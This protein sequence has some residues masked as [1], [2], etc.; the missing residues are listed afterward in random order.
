MEPMSA[1]A[2][3]LQHEI[4][5]YTAL[6][7]Y[8]VHQTDTT[9]QLRKPKQFN[10]LVFIVL[11]VLLFIVGAVLYAAWYATQQDQFVYLTVGADG[12]VRASGAGIT[13][14]TQLQA[15][16]MARYGHMSTAKLENELMKARQQRLMP[17]LIHWMEDNLAARRAEEGTGNHG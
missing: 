13:D 3:A 6:G 12:V 8:V 15:S 17:E 4:Q 5:K 16:W 14:V 2:R 7:Y 1:P 10:F 9:A 11:G